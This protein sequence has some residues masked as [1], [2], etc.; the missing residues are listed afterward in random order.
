MGGNNLI[1]S[2][3]HDMELALHHL[4]GIL[5]VELSNHETHTLLR[6]SGIQQSQECLNCIAI[7]CVGQ[8]LNAVQVNLT[9][10]ADLLGT[11]EKAIDRIVQDVYSVI[12]ENNEILTNKQKI[13]ERNPWLFETI[14]H[15]LVHSSRIR[16]EFHPVGQLLG[17]LPVHGKVKEPGLD[18]VAIYI[19]DDI[20]LGI[21]EMKAWENDPSAALKKSFREIYSS[22]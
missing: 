21:G 18:L 2:I 17:L 7:Y 12:G 6:I 9:I 10:R 5:D 16:P 14:S 13:E 11:D 1:Q 15:L 22:R 3:E 20:G 8:I 19:S 4:C